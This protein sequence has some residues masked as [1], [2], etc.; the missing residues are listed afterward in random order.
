MLLV[1]CWWVDLWLL[2]CL[3]LDLGFVAFVA[4]NMCFIVCWFGYCCLGCVALFVYSGCLGCY[5]WFGSGFVRGWWLSV[6]VIVVNSVGI[7]FLCKFVVCCVILGASY[8]L[9]VLG[10]FCLFCSLGRGACVVGGCF[11]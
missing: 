6:L 7:G 9:L 11:W 8:W 1:W 4:G 10:V 5:L 2:V 3:L